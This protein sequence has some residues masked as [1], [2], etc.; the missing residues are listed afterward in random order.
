MPD[1]ASVP[2][3]FRARIG[4]VSVA[5]TVPALRAFLEQ[6]GTVI[7]V[8]GSTV[9]G[10]HLGLPVADALVERGPDA[11]ERHLPAE[12]FYIPGSVLRV[13]V[14]TTAAAAWGMDAA[15]DVMFDESPAFRL[16]SDGGNGG[17]R[18]LAWYDGPEPLRSGWAWGQQYLD[19]V[20]AAAEAD[21]GR[22]RLLM[23]G[24]E[25]TF[26]AQPHGTFKFLFNGIYEAMANPRAQ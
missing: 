6:G 11:S 23:F 3:E 14:D 1:P 2:A 22:G 7:T 21:V 8:G 15:T 26:R 13:R 24:P 10:R 16:L 17:V 25:I 18:R 19:G 20:T 5:R 9:L 12:K 4:N